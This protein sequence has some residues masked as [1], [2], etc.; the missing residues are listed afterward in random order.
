MLALVYALPNLAACVK[1]P[2][3]PFCNLLQSQA[4]NS[5]SHWQAQKKPM[6]HAHHCAPR[7]V[8]AYRAALRISARAKASA[9]ARYSSGAE[10]VSSQGTSAPLAFNPSACS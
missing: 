8:K 5:A 7:S 2:L 4:E 3:R 6:R 10:I 9:A 1:D